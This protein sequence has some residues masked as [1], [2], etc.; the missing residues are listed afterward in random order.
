MTAER[1]LAQAIEATNAGDY[2]QAAESFERAA[3]LA[4][5]PDDAAAAFESAARLHI[6]LRDL[7]RAAALVERADATAPGSPRLL[8]VRAELADGVGDVHAR[9]AAWQAVAERG[10]A[11]HRVHALTQLGYLARELGD[12]AAAATRFAAAVDHGGPVDPWLARE[13]GLEI[14]IALTEAGDHHGAT[15]RLDALEAGLPRDDRGL[16]GRVLGQRG[17]L[18][19][20]RGDHAR[21]LDYAER[22]RAAAVGRDDV[23]TYLAASTLIAGLHEAAGRL[24]EAYDTYV[25]A[26]ESLA[27]LLG[28]QGRA[29]VAPA[30]Q[31]F[32][33]RLGAPRFEE[34]WT[35]WVRRR[36][37]AEPGA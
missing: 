16:A 36:R 11:E 18:A 20:A 7:D 8:R 2:R 15:A 6:M 29:M 1:L 9:V 13:L 23:M 37:G 4:A 32:E 30:I 31:L 22:A 28:D 24:V 26:R 17:V 12:H 5:A 35:A 21:A 10:L 33:E 27:D 19:M 14:V 34:I 25:R 3:A